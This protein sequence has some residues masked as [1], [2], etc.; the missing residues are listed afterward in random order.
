MAVVIQCNGDR[1]FGAD[2]SDNQRPMRDRFAQYG[3]GPLFIRE[4]A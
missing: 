3:V 4:N 2:Q 1:D